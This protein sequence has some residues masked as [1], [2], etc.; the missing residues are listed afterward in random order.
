[1]SDMLVIYMDETPAYE[2]NKRDGLARMQ[3]AYVQRMDDDMDKG[4]SLNGEQ[5]RS[6]N[7]M[8][9]TQFVIGRLLDALS[10]NDSRAIA[11]LCRYLA[12]R[13]PNLDAIRVE[14]DGDEYSVDLVYS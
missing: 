8:Q 6:P 14:E 2:F 9:R 11:M 4:I 1:M 5:V 7:Q 12:H 10:I 3:F 13:V